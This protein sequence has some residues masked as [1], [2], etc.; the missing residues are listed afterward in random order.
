[1]CDE[2]LQLIVF[3]FIEYLTSTICINLQLGYL[4]FDYCLH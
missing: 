3:N 2:L 1:M 4:A